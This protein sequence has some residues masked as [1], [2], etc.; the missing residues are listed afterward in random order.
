MG[1][2]KSYE[3]K[4]LLSNIHSHQPISTTDECNIHV[5]HF[6]QQMQ[7]YNLVTLWLLLSKAP[8]VTYSLPLLIRIIMTNVQ[9]I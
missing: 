7:Q 8:L 4:D 6:R 9:V 2:K 3:F 1:T 5:L